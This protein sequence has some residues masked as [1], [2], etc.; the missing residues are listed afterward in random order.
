MGPIIAR[1]MHLDFN[2]FEFN[3]PLHI[4]H[5]YSSNLLGQE[6]S[7]FSLVLVG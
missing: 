1:Y 7:D 3:N 2:T 6:V 4:G 5:C